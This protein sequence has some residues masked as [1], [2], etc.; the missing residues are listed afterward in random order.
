MHIRSVRQTDIRNELCQSLLMRLWRLVIAI[1]LGTLLAGA[2]AQAEGYTVSS[3]RDGLYRFTAGN[4]HSMFW[5]TDDGI[6]VI[7]TIDSEAASWL[8]SELESRFALPVRYV[9]YS[10]NHFDHI[11]GA[12]VFD[13]PGTVF[14]AHELAR[15]DIVRSKAQTRVPD[16]TF[17]DEL[18]IHLSGQT[19][20]LRYHGTNNGRGSISMLFED[21]RVLFV[22]DWIV[23]GRM[24]WKDLEGYDIEGVIRSTT[25]VLLL[26]WDVFVGGHAEIGDR[27]DVKRYLDY[28]EALYAAVRDGMIAGKSLEMLQEEIRLDE[29]SDLKNYPEW[30]P[31]NVA[32]VY[33]T[34]ADQSYLLKRP[35][36]P[37]PGDPR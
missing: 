21:Q 33:R 5:V 37:A 27:D 31:L 22:V 4:S 9:I 32:G 7:D 34:L 12:E 10:H 19:L 11:Y 29:Y 1:F 14:V 15:A 25:D 26:D 2:P 35:E 30:L 18:A 8:K 20:R 13:D 17:K 6:V 16:V 28:L 23:V 24:P 3:V 36:T